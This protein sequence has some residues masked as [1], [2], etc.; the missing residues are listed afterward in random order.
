MAITSP[1]DFICVCGW[2]GVGV[3][4]GGGGQVDSVWKG[5]GR[6]IAAQ[7]VLEVQGSGSGGL[8]GLCCE[9]RGDRCGRC[10][11]Q[12]SAVACTIRVQG[13]G[14]GVSELD[15]WCATRTCVVSS[16]FVPL[17]FSK[18]NLGIFVTM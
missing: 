13:S 17:N 15:V 4:V 7:L 8:V 18:A 11:G 14:L 10:C 2:V 6:D 9:A 16:A 12:L 1:T 5:F 3:W